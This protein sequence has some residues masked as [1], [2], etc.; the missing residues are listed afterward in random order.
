MARS[1]LKNAGELA[2]AK[3]TA[4]GEMPGP[5]TLFITS[6]LVATPKPSMTWK[7]AYS[8]RDSYIDGSKAS[9]TQY[10]LCLSDISQFHS[11]KR[12][13]MT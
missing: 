11:A 9:P 12:A 8:V 13:D 7:I 4:I 2:M 3:F 6:A 1:I 5:T 10:L